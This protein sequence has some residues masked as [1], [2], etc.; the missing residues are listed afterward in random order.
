VCIA[1]NDQLS[2]AK[3]GR[4]ERLL[5]SNEKLIDP[6]KCLARP[7]FQV[8]DN[9][10]VSAPAGVQLAA[11]VTELV[12]QGRFD[13]HVD[14][15][16]LKHERKTSPLYI[17]PDFRQS[18]HNLLALVRGEETHTL[19]HSRVRDGTLDVVLEKSTIKG[20]GFRELH[21]ATVGSISE[22]TAPGLMDHALFSRANR[23]GY[24][25]SL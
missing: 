14:V 13:I 19:E 2:I 22:T 12:D 10:I 25:V 24:C 7:Q 17:S 16:T 20:D 23:R 18:P 11:N 3:A 4:H 15:F 1:W 5:V 8:R 9:L 6:I 21:H